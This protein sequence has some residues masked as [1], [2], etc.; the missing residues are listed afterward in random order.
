ME[1]VDREYNHLLHAIM[2]VRLQLL[3][4]PLGDPQRDRLYRELLAL[5]KEAFAVLRQRIAAYQAK[6][7]TDQER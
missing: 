2:T 4:T 6:Q 1:D 7:A 5:Y 3:T